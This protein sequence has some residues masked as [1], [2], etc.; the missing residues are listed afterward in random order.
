MT[1][2]NRYLNQQRYQNYAAI[3]DAK[4]MKD[5]QVANE[6][7]VSPSTFT[8]WKTGKSTPAFGNIVKIAECLNVSP[9]EF[10]QRSQ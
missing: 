1:E 9:T 10:E 7:G 3:R 4:G 5:F 6:T 2:E 8:D